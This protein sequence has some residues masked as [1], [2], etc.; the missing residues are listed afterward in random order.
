MIVPMGLLSSCATA[1]GLQEVLIGGEF[2][3]GLCADGRQQHHRK[4]GMLVLDLHTQPK[5]GVERLHHDVRNDH[6]RQG[7]GQFLQ[8]FLGASGGDDVIPPVCQDGGV[9]LQ[10]IDVVLDGRLRLF[11]QPAVLIILILD[12]G[13]AWNVT[14]EDLLQRL[15]GVGNI[16]FL[17]PEIRAS[18]PFSRIDHCHQF[19]T[20]DLDDRGRVILHDLALPSLLGSLKRVS[21]QGPPRN[22][23]SCLLI[24]NRRDN[25][26]RSIFFLMRLEY[27][28]NP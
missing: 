17:P 19:R 23:I 15:F 25:V 26:F 22:S 9:Y 7:L 8:A 6:V 14:G 28:E 21:C 24:A 12:L 18:R 5:A 20:I 4:I 11:H 16:Q 3:A 13:I 10:E 1:G 2:Q 27:K